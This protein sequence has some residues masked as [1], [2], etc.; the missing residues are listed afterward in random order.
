MS[1]FSKIKVIIYT[2]SALVSVS[3]SGQNDRVASIEFNKLV[4]DFGDIQMSSG[5]QSYT[6]TFKNI[7]QQPVVIQ[8]VISSC[9]CTT[10]EWT[11]SPVKPGE[12]GKI[13]VTFLND[14]GPYPFDKSLTVYVT[15]SPKP[16]ILRIK[17][18][19]HE[20]Q[21]SIKQLFPETF[22]P[23][24]L[25][26][27]PVD[28]GQI[29]QG[30]VDHETIEIANIS[31]TPIK[32]T[33]ADIT[34]GLT[35]KITPATLA[36]D[37]KGE[38]LISIDTR[39]QTNWGLTSYMATPVINGKKASRKIV[40]TATIRED[41][42]NLTKTEI[43]QA[44]LPMAS[45]SSFNFGTVSS[46]NKIDTT[47]EIKN[48]GK[49]DLIIHKIDINEKGVETTNPGKIASGST[50]KIIVKV[51]T[52]GHFGEKIYIL[53]LITNSPSRPIVNLLLTGE[54]IK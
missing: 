17:G 51:N 29:T 8:T 37:S 53:T 50:G 41:F 45:K 7:S 3:L 36:P 35:L 15:G 43:D 5:K 44:P 33:F 46:G 22:G 49:R 19:V 25:R 34:K 6:F 24:A 1:V 48:L 18:I 31:R 4:H 30:S 26:R 13:A 32:V 12:T 14:Q 54:I 52:A 40:I 23:M 39:T 10:P 2:V 47:F 38:L 27:S 21:K 20:K 9:G 28:V 16:L 11:K 42:S